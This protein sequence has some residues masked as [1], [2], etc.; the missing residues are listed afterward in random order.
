MKNF[1]RIASGLVLCI[2]VVNDRVEHVL[3]VLSFPSFV[4]PP[5]FVL[6]IRHGRHTFI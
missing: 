6:F 2:G 4:N 5:R 1:E 3:H